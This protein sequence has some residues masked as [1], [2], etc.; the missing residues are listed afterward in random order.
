MSGLQ[1]WTR[2]EI[3]AESRRLEMETLLTGRQVQILRLAA[4]GY[5]TAEIAQ[6]LYLGG[7]T[8]KL[9]LREVATMLGARVSDRTHLVALAYE[10][11][12]LQRG[13]ATAGG[14][15]REPAPEAADA[16]S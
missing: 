6:Q 1:I 13:D 15:R 8:V 3:E 7:S 2:E 4:G 5:T 11:G 9:H 14:G 16:T 10:C 12:V